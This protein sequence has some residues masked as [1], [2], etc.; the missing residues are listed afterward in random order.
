MS[1]E[2]GESDG[3]HLDL[4]GPRPIVGP[5]RVSGQI[6]KGEVVAA[7][8]SEVLRKDDLIIA[9]AT[10]DSVEDAKL[11]WQTVKALHQEGTLG[12]VSA[13]IVEKRPSGT[14]DI[15]S[16]DTTTKNLAWAGVAVG[17]ALSVI[18]PPL[19]VVA[20]GPT[21]A[22]TGA[23]GLVGGVVGHLWKSVP[24]SDMKKL[25]KML[26]KGESA[27]VVVA[28]DKAANEIDAAMTRAIKKATKKYEKGE[29]GAAYDEFVKGLDSASVTAADAALAVAGAQSYAEAVRAARDADAEV[30][31]GA[32]PAVATEEEA[33]VTTEEEAGANSELESAEAAQ[34]AR[35]V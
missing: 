5:S 14:L 3:G 16:H 21:L 19:G 27:L 18:F 28:V 10:Y 2:G 24:R 32:V 26:R 15:T 30:V 4:L 23:S 8:T 7:V 31:Q 25:A 13:G 17:A 11:D 20:L 34:A 33:A 35:V 9:V 12:H 6:M 29:V 1:S 22:L